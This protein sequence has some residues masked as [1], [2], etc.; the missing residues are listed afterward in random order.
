MWL[1]VEAQGKHARCTVMFAAVAIGWWLT[2]GLCALV[3][4][5]ERLAQ[6]AKLGDT[7]SLANVSDFVVIAS[8]QLRCNV[9]V[10]VVGIASDTPFSFCC[11]MLAH[12]Q[13]A[14]AHVNSDD[15]TALHIGTTVH[16][17]PLLWTA[18]TQLTINSTPRA[19]AQLHV[20][21]SKTRSTFCCQRWER[22]ACANV[23]G[24]H[25]THFLPQG[26]FIDQAN[27]RGETPLHVACADNTLFE[28]RNLPTPHAVR[29]V[30]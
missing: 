2:W 21:D 29:T 9:C 10:S 6:S 5:R 11:Q 3:G 8:A 26:A 23:L 27:K 14:N 15:E 28:V 4:C 1:K 22:I 17:R 25:L 20:L 30:E 12:G 13:D 7:D 18:R 19:L 24:T 16:D